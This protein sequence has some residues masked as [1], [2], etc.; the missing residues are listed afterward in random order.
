MT[1][2]RYG[3]GKRQPVFAA[4]WLA[5]TCTAALLPAAEQ[6]SAEQRSAAHQRHSSRSAHFLLYTDLQPDRA[7]KLLERLEQTVRESSDYW[8]RPLQGLIECYVIDDLKNWP[9]GSL[10]HPMARLVVDRIGGVTIV[11]SEGAG[12]QTRNKVVI[13]ATSRKG[14]AEHEA[15]HAYCAMVFGRTGPAWYR[16]G[17]AQAFAYAQGERPGL[18]C[19]EELVA[20][21][22]GKQRKPI[23][24]VI[25]VGEFSKRLYGSIAQKLDRHE[26]K[27]VAGLIPIS[28][29]SDS[30]IQKLDQLKKEYA[31]SWL[32]CHLLLHNPNYSTRFKALG[33]GYLANRRDRFGELFSPIMKQLAF[34]YDFTV[35]HFAHGYRVDLC[36]WDWDKR[37]RCASGGSDIRVRVSADRGYQATGLLVKRGDKY[38]IATSG[39]WK[40]GPRRPSTRAVSD[41]WGRGGLEGV[42]F[43]DFQLSEPFAIAG[44]GHFQATSD[45]CLYLRCRDEWSQLVDNEGSIVVSLRRA[46]K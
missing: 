41:R 31:W 19:P 28:D 23:S 6:R 15:V 14:V 43:R 36:Y 20:D 37:F 26:A 34:E 46:R 24:E 30:D 3:G 10:P 21:L 42:I 45:G 35:D 29:W 22:T 13:L 9:K 40:T 18:R 44:A 16:E 39:S 8:R 32:A 11:D 38:R 5:I 7:D 27:H 2:V 33:Q 25:D 17:I 12:I 1:H 4:I